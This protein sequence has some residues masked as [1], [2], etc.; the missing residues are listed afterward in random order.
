MFMYFFQCA[1]CKEYFSGTPT[2]GH[3]CYRQMNVNREYCF[4]PI[5]QNDCTRSPEPLLQ[6]RTVFFAVQPKYV[7]VDIRVTIDVTQGGKVYLF[8]HTR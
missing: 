5:T 4:A 7:N 6:G 3:Q 2:E 8:L 1:V